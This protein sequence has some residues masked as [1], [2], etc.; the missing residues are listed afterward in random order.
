M[1]DVV[2][3][4]RDLPECRKKRIR[5]WDDVYQTVREDIRDGVI[6]AGGK[7]NGKAAEGFSK[8]EIVDMFLDMGKTVDSLRVEVERLSKMAAKAVREERK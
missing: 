3:R 4:M 6:S 8:K 1:S 7:A 2:F 5:K